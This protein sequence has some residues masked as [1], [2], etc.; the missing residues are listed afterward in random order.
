MVLKKDVV[1]QTKSEII[2]LVVDIDK[3]AKVDTDLINE[4]GLIK[5]NPNKKKFEITHIYPH[6]HVENSKLVKVNYDKRDCTSCS[7]ALRSYKDINNKR[8]R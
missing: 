1:A 3:I 4:P 8:L 7:E 2:D 6:M 5:A